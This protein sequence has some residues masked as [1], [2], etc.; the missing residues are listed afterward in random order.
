MQ[1]WAEITKEKKKKNKYGAKKQ[2][3]DRETFASK[4]EYKR[5][6]MLATMEGLGEIRALKHEET[7]HFPKLTSGRSGQ[8]LFIKPDFTYQL[9]IKQRGQ[10]VL[11]TLDDGSTAWDIRQYCEEHLPDYDTSMLL[12]EPVEDGVID[13]WINIVEDFKSPVTFKKS[14]FLWK[15]AILKHFYPQY[16]QQVSFRGGKIH[17]MV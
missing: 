17:E 14:D 11:K 13:V 1:N 9:R 6:H 10:L 16:K 3:V 8:K 7:F 2:T 12:F 4:G 5:Y 15:W